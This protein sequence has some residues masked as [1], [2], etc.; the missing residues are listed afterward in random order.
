MRI[1]LATVIIA[2]SCLS[3]LAVSTNDL[4]GTWF[5]PI[6]S[7]RLRRGRDSYN[8]EF[9]PDGTFKSWLHR[10]TFRVQE[11]GRRTG[12]FVV[13]SNVVTMIS[14]RTTNRLTYAIHGR[15]PVLI[16]ETTIPQRDKA[17]PRIYRRKDSKGTAKEIRDLRQEEAEKV[18][19][20]R[21]SAFVFPHVGQ[22]YLMT[23][24]AG[25]ITNTVPAT[26]V[27]RFIGGI[28]RTTMALHPRNDD[29]AKLRIEFMHTGREPLASIRREY[30]NPWLKKNGYKTFKEGTGRIK[31]GWRLQKTGKP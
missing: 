7:S 19:K 12:T 11:V 10:H 21:T 24:S 17:E 27:N 16:P 1:L 13:S 18:K 3:G 14:T 26:L 20:E 25:G 28:D 23:V 9:K 4:V 15:H 31:F 30:L 2:S 5:C 29:G 22:R 8:I 6:E